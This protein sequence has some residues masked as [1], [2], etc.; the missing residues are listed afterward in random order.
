MERVSENFMTSIY[1]SD[2]RIKGR[3]TFDIS[4]VTVKDDRPAV[5]VSSNFILSNKDHLTDNIRDYSFNLATWEPNRFKLDGSFYIPDEVI[6]NNGNIGWCSKNLC[7]ETGVFIPSEELIFE[8]EQSHSIIGVT[9]TFDTVNNEY[10]TDFIIRAYSDNNLINEVIVENNTEVQAVIMG[11]FLL[12]DKLS[13]TINKW[14]IPYRRARVAEVDFGIVRV[15]EGK[16]LMR[17]DLTEEID[18]LSLNVPSSE[19]R[20]VVE[21]LDRKFDIPNVEGYYK[22]LQEKQQ[23][24]PELGIELENGSTEYIKLGVFYLN[25]WRS[26]EEPL[27]ASF[28][29]RNVI[30]V[31]NEYDYE[32]LNPKSN[33]TLYQL[34]SEIFE[35]CDITDYEIDPVLHEIETKGLVE[36]R[37][38]RN[39]LQMIA[40]A[41]MC[42]VYVNRQGTLIIKR[43]SDNE[44]PVDNVK[45]YNMYN[46]PK[47]KLIN[48][49]KSITIM[50]YTDLNMKHEISF[51]YADKGETKTINNTLI[52]T[53]EHAT[54]V[55]EWIASHYQNRAIYTV[56]WRGNPAHELGDLV[57]LEHYINRYEKTMLT[58]IDLEYRGYLDGVLEAKGLIV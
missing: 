39:V 34:A 29:A 45:L 52:N 13:I 31:M 54:D 11:Q 23:V 14:A 49:L 42:N 50:Y 1:A 12:F 56:K 2:R 57:L 16:E 5:S 35:I 15:F 40:L 51:T 33:C 10:A 9:I 8:F 24:I 30:D 48:P 3:V 22:Y 21:N 32:N 25:D 55:A 38:C 4:D 6:E 58:K 26:N 44:I 7:D 20:F 19:F 37:T 28:V 53:I 36:K 46:Y 17:M 47:I 18:L 41:G 27:S 43:V